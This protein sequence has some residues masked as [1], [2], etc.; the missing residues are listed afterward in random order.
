[1]RRRNWLGRL[2][3]RW[4]KNESAEGSRIGK[5]Q[6]AAAVQNLAER[7]TSCDARQRRGVRQPPGAFSRRN[8]NALC[9]PN[10]LMTSDLR[11]YR[12]FRESLQKQIYFPFDE[13]LTGRDIDTFLTREE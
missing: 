9:C 2:T 3:R 8:T 13:S 6:R 7:L 1:M 12:L 4:R 11:I 10:Q 5:R